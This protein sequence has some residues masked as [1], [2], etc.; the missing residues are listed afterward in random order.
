[1]VKNK[2]GAWVLRNSF[3]MKSKCKGPREYSMIDVISKSVF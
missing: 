2:E 1:M 3:A